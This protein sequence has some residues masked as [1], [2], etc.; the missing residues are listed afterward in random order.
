MPD[1]LRFSAIN[2]PSPKA[3]PI[4][5]VDVPARLPGPVQGRACK[6]EHGQARQEL[7]RTT[8]SATGQEVAPQLQYAPLP[9]AIKPRRRPRSTRL[10]CNGERAIGELA[11]G[12]R[13]PHSS[14]AAA[15]RSSSGRRARA[16]PDPLLQW[17]LTALAALILVLI[18]FFFIRLLHRGAAGVRQ[19]RRTSASS[20]TTTGTSSQEHLRRA[21]RWS[22]ARSSPRRSRWSSACRSRSPPRSTSPSCAR[23]A[24]RAAADHPRRA[25]GRGAVGRLRPVGHLRPDPRSSSR[26]SSGSPTRSRFL[27]L[28]RRHGRRPQLLHRR[29]DPGDHDPADRQR[30]LARGHGHRAAPTTRRPRWRSAP[31]AGR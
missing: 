24:L 13:Q 17:V 5:V 11:D 27:P 15:A 3:Y 25:A 12:S 8:R 16:L 18:A 28:R 26:P 31:R 14:A 30:D 19:V 9:D 7:A 22:S 23:G 1:D 29:A 6:R 20:S 2:S 4:S 10:Q 21:G